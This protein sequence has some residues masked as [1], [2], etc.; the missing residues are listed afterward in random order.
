LCRRR[1]QRSERIIETPEYAAGVVRLIR[2]M[3]ARADGD[4]D[5]L[6]W[7]AG[8]VDHARAA[9]ALAVDGCRA[10]GYSDAEIGQALGISRQAA[11]K[12]FPRQPKVDAGI[13]GAGAGG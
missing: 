12:R 13:P 11:W 5:A 7:L 1:G 10:R 4:L 6:G 9:L 2:R 3:G 8:A